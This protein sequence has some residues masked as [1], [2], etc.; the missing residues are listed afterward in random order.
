MAPTLG[1]GSTAVILASSSPMNS[2]VVGIFSSLFG[3]LPGA[4]MQITFFTE[5]AAQA[6]VRLWEQHGFSAVRLGTVVVSDCPTLWA[7]PIISRAIGFHQVERL[8]VMS[9]NVA[10]VQP[11]TLRRDVHRNPE[12]RPKRTAFCL[13]NTRRTTRGKCRSSPA[14]HHLAL[15]RAKAPHPCPRSGRARS[16]R[17]PFR[18]GSQG[19]H[20]RAARN[21]R[22]L[23]SFLWALVL[24]EKVRTAC[25]STASRC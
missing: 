6:A 25:W 20:H 3:F 1:T 24:A 10:L 19:D 14:D 4:I 16:R 5:H 21:R 8:D 11:A 23:A 12:D 17:A 13:Q 18:H 15:F 7:V 22:P 9:S 2:G